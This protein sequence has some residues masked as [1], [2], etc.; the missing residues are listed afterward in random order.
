MR[1]PSLNAASQPARFPLPLAALVLLLV[2]IGLAAG[3]QYVAGPEAT[4][5]LVTETQLAPVPLELAQVP[6]GTARLPVAVNGYALTETYTVGGPLI[7]PEAAAALALVLGVCLV[8][9]LTFISFLPRLSFAIGM[10]AVIF[11]LM[12]LNLDALGV[13]N[14]TKQYFL[15]LTL[16]LLVGSAY[17]FH[18]FFPQVSSPLRLLWFGLLVS[19]LSAFLLVA[20]ADPAPLAALHIAS[21]ATQSGTV[22]IALWVLWAGIENIRLLLWLNTQAE[23]PQSRFGLWPFLLASGLYLTVLALYY[24][25]NGDVELLPGL[26][27]DPYLL[28]LLATAVGAAAM[29]QRQATLRAWVPAKATPYLLGVLAAYAGATLAYAF[30]TQNDPIIEA[31]RYFTATTFLVL[32]VAFLLYILVNF[33]P[34]IRQK[35]RVYRVVFEPR[36]LPFY[37]VYLLGIGCI[38]AILLRNRLDLYYR[39]QAGYYNQLGDLTRWQSE[40]QPAA[41]ALALL[42][43]RYYAESDWMDRFNH[44][45]SLGRAALYRSRTQRQNEINALRRALSRAPSEKISLRLAS[46]FNTPAD[47]FERQRTLWAGLRATPGSVPLASELAQLYTRSALTDSVQYYQQQ[48]LKEEPKN[49][50]LRSNQLAFLVQ[51]QRWAEARPYLQE[52]AK[53]EAFR[54]N[55]QLVALVHRTQSA[56]APASTDTALTP[57]SFALL[58]H[59]ALLRVRNRDTT[60]LPTLRRLPRYTTNA[61]YA[62][63]LLFLQALTQQ[64]GGRPA[65]A[66]NTLIPLATAQS[67]SAAYYQ[68]LQGLWLLEQGAA[69]AAAA[70]LSQA[71]ELDP[72]TGQLARAY[73]LALASQPDSA[74]QVAARAVADPTVA[75]QARRLL[76]TL[77]Y[78][79]AA[80]MLAPDS[81]KVDYLVLLGRS[82]PGVARAAIATS[83]RQPALRRQAAYAQA[84]AAW[85]QSQVAEVEELVAAAAPP[86]STRSAE[87]SAWN[88]LRGHVLAQQQDLTELRR[89]LSQAYFQGLDVGYATYF[90]ALVAAGPT[91][92]DALYQQVIREAPYVEQGLLAAARFYQQRRQ[93]LAAYQALLRGIEYNPESI[94]LLKGYILA[95]FAAGLPDYAQEPL[96]KLRTLLSPQEYAIFHS[97][98]G[99][100]RPAPLAPSWN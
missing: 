30:A 95:A 9:A 97:Q 21:Y 29:A 89:F 15:L 6:V 39:A 90:R 66:Q 52:P 65:S 51:Q 92:A 93:P 25:S 68:Q 17:G 31:G 2:L 62:E 74:R 34:L 77:R 42:A 76:T 86:V 100:V 57:G 78:T 79:P 13:F 72:R 81:S 46:L 47:F 70:R 59:S 44:K 1:P 85:A 75:L 55:Q 60:L 82:L 91:Q 10:S 28:L 48:A 50:V 96:R 54:S 63:Q 4:L 69:P 64:Y 41:D 84:V 18:A 38:G 87:A 45:A 80:A 11:L 19:G 67:P 58:Y 26:R 35:L 12:S 49:E 61:P 36:R 43:E 40:Q 16:V 3:W 37:V 20:G 33:A 83:V 5:P 8:Y 53:S 27:L 7:R 14:D 99:V 22:A 88:V 56:P 23:N 32:G 98:P 94:P 24:F 73:A 71:A